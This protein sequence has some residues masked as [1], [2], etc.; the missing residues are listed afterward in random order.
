MDRTETE[1]FNRGTVSCPYTVH[2]Y[3]VAIEAGKTCDG[4]ATRNLGI[5]SRPIRAQCVDVTDHQ[6]AI[7]IYG[8]NLFSLS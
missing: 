8:N 2:T 7:D 1:I 5:M 6:I 4:G 3:G